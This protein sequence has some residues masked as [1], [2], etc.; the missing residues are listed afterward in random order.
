MSAEK[1]MKQLKRV[2]G[3]AGLDRIP[4]PDETKGNL[5]L[6]DAAAAARTKSR[7]TARLDLRLTP[8]EK[9]RLELRAVAEGISINELHSRM[10]AFYEQTHGRVELT[11]AKKRDG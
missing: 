1:A 5:A 4:T 6:P 3:K 11:S 7:R 2:W 9:Q 10:Q 8:E